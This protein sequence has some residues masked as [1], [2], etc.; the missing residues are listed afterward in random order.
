[1]AGQAGALDIIIVGYHPWQVFVDQGF[2]TRVGHLIET[3]NHTPQVGKLLYVPPVDW[4]ELVKGCQPVLS[5]RWWEV[6]RSLPKVWTLAFRPGVPA[7]Y[8]T[9][10]LVA[11]LSRKLG[12][13]NPVLWLNTPLA[14]PYIGRV[15][16]SL[17]VFDAVDNWL[18]H[19]HYRGVK[20][21]VADGYQ[22]IRKQ[23]DI[24]FTVSQGLIK[25]FAGSRG[26]VHWIPNGVDMDFVQRA[27]TQPVPPDL[28]GLRRPVLGY[29]GTIQERIDTRLLGYLATQMPT[30]TIALIGPALGSIRK[31]LARYANI[32]L[33]GLRHYREVPGYMRGFNV[34]LI[35]HVVNSATE[36]MDPI[37]VYEYLALGKPVVTTRVAGARRMQGLVYL[38]SNPKEFY[39]GVVQA[40]QEPSDRVTRRI[41]AAR[42]HS[43]RQRVG[44]IMACLEAAKRKGHPKG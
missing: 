38:A 31:V 34:C 19:V 36:S 15:G 7:G 29:V 5:G 1:M 9:P 11:E 4:P 26:T 39:L 24:I 32:R 13:L 40:L 27:M 21:Q 12:F 41:L 8:E 6:Y 44:Q 25:V 28:R 14:T 22:A 23:A 18:D 16:E 3:M 17:V 35:P 37:K 43:W 33:L 10:A 42:S 30:A 2:R 20:K